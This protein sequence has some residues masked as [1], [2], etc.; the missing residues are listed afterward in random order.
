M[1]SESNRLRSLASAVGAAAEAASL[2][3]LG[4]TA[5]LAAALDAFP[6]ILFAV[7]QERLAP[8]AIAGEARTL[9]PGYRR[10]LTISPALRP[11]A[12]SASAAE[13][14]EDFLP[15]LAGGNAMKRKQEFGTLLIAVLAMMVACGGENSR[16]GHRAS[17]ASSLDVVQQGCDFGAWST[18]VNMG[19]VLNTT[20]DDFHPA[21][22]AN[23]LSLY[24]S[25]GVVASPGVPAGEQNIMVTHRACNSTAC[26]WGPPTNVTALNAPTFKTAV[27]NVSPDGLSIYFHST[28]PNPCGAEGNADLYV[29]YRRDP[30]DDFGWQTPVNLGCEPAGPNTAR[31]ENAPLFFKN[32]A[33]GREELYFSA[34][35]PPP[36]PPIPGGLGGSDLMLST[37][38]NATF[39]WSPGVLIKSL[40]S[41]Q[42]DDRTAIRQDGLEMILS[43]NRVGTIGGTDLW[44]TTRAST[45]VDWSTPTNLGAPLNTTFTDGGPALSFDGK[46]LYFTS[47]RQPGGFGRLDLWTSTRNLFCPPTAKCQDKTV[48]AD[49]AC[50]GSASINAGSTDSDGDNDVTCTQSSNGPFPLGKTQVTLTCVDK[51]SQQSSTCTATVTV[52]DTT[53]PVITCPADQTLECTDE[54]AIATF[55]PTATDNCGVASVQCSPPSGSTFPEDPSPTADTCVATDTSGNQAS[56]GFQVAV[57]DT[58]PPI[59]TPQADANGFSATLWPPNHSMQTVSLSDCIASIT[60]QCDGTAPATIVRVTSDELVKR[61]GKKSEDMVIVDSK[62][63]QLRADRD[64]SGNGRVYTIFAN[65]TDDDGNTTQVACKVQVPH[66]QFGVPAVDSGAV[67]CVGQGC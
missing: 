52:V 46:T 57:N 47:N 11:S 66:D 12:S 27:P 13:P 61:N 43:S 67:S 1:S 29:S 9:F 40:S 51:A 58:L 33:A 63:V 21:T 59:V 26:P 54:G 31:S 10:S 38:P 62:T 25:R 36:G 20:I 28:R 6:G 8:V 32:T 30:N 37:R 41:P 17:R 53:P 18:P 22:T 14:N 5:Q 34:A 16:G 45:L 3:E 44:V 2:D 24:F 42:N 7:R 49:A 55:A 39:P 48:P 15:A 23:G 65:V 64:G 19:P 4:R 60:D 35:L 50:H 56:C